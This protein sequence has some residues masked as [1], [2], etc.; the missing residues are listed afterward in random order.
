[1]RLRGEVLAVVQQLA[2]PGRAGREVVGDRDPGRGQLLD[3]P[4]VLGG[5]GAFLADL[6]RLVL[7]VVAA[8]QRVDDPRGRAGVAVELG[9]QGQVLQGQLPG[10]VPG[11][12]PGLRGDPGRLAARS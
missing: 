2:Q 9:Q 3:Q 11:G 6:L 10:Q 5:L 12:R 1:M 4:L 8:L 7:D